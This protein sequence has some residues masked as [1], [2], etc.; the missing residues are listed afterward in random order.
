MDVL[1]Y[2]LLHFLLVRNY[3]REALYPDKVRAKRF[4]A[5]Y[6]ETAKEE[7][8]GVEGKLCSKKSSLRVLGDLCGENSS[9]PHIN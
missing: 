7:R 8:G 4:T 6:A 9:M 2:T 1:P 3:Y 5:E